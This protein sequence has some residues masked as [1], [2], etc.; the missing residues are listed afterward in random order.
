MADRRLLLWAVSV[1]IVAALALP[2]APLVHGSGA[3]TSHVAIAS[4]TSPHSATPRSATPTMATPTVGARAAAQSSA[5]AAVAAAHIPSRYVFYPNYGADVQRTGNVITP[6]SVHA[7]API[8]VADLGVVNTSGTAVGTTLTTPSFWGSITFNSLNAFYLDDD[9]PDY[10][11]AQLNTVVNNITLFGQSNNSFWTQNVF[12]YSSR[13]NLLQFLDNIWNFSSPAFDLTANVF[14]ATSPNGTL[15]APTFYYGLGPVINITMP[16]TVNVYTNVTTTNVNGSPD[17]IVY[18]NYSVYKSGAWVQGGAYDWAIFNSQVPG[19]PTA[20]IEDPLYLVDGTN[21]TP[22][23]FLPYDAELVFCG[24]GGGSSTEILGLDATLNLWYW[25]TTTDTY[26]T[27]PVAEAYGTDTGETAD[28]IAEWYDA[29]GTVHAGPGPSLPYLFWN[30]SPTAAPG[31]ITIGGSVTPSNAFVFVNQSVNYNF[32]WAA[33]APVPTSGVAGYDVPVG[34][35]SVSV[36]LSNYDPMNFTILGSTPSSYLFTATLNADSA[37]GI[38][39]P[40]WAWDNAQLAAISTSGAGTS[41][42]PYMIANDQSGSLNPEFA[43]FNDFT[44]PAFAG[45]QLVQTTAYVDVVSPASFE[46]NFEGRVLHSALVQGLPT[47]NNLQ[48]ELYG[49]SHVSLWNATGITGWFSAANLNGFPLA[50]LMVWNSSHDLIG[51]NTFWVEGASLLIFGAGGNTVWGNTFVPSPN[52]SDPAFADVVTW[53]TIPVGPQVYENND[54]IYNNAFE[55]LI[56]A[57]SPPSTIYGETFYS[58]FSLTWTDAWNISWAPASAWTIDNGFN[59]T[60]VITGGAYQGGNFWWNLGQF[61]FYLP[62]D[63]GGLIF[64]GG[65]WLPLFGD[66]VAFSETGLP[67]GTPWEVTIAG[68]TID[69]AAATTAFQLLDGT[70]TYAVTP[71]PG[72]LTNPASGTLTLVQG[73]AAV[74]VSFVAIPTNYT[75]TLAESGLPGG[76]AWTATLNGASSTSTS[77]TIAFTA[78]N[79][80]YTWGVTPVSGEILAVAS[81]IVTVDGSNVTVPVGFSA[82]AAHAYSVTFVALGLASGTTW[83][84]TL[85]GTTVSSAL[86]EIAFSEPNGSYTYTVGAVSGYTT[87]SASGTATVSGSSPSYDIPFTATSVT[88]SGTVSPATATVTVDGASVSVTGGSFSLTVAPGVHAVRASASGYFDYANNVS[89]AVAHNASVAIVLNAQSSGSSTSGGSLSGTN[90]ALLAGLGVLAVIFLIGMVYFWS[91]VRR[92]PV[93]M[94]PEPEAKSAEASGKSGPGG[95]S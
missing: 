21:L 90:L 11:G 8:G 24:P 66:A 57:Y 84:V 43:R 93:V 86:Q 28:G 5:V 64:V 20:T 76:T 12:E 58:S 39:T 4:G 42:N 85:S 17:D 69:S 67:A 88:L 32:S 72:Y 82:P 22:T 33:W 9:S 71:E 18:F 60:G 34:D 77:A 23:N 68:L 31:F 62:Y 55:T 92:G 49:T 59:L 29:T 87:T 15:V 3:A 45:L 50:P 81:G 53:G 61:G 35:Y 56:P 80:S 10:T 83:S 2:A 48:I 52:L 16:F 51:N 37:M 73:P 7:P 78:T 1:L 44:F 13:S 40:L 27:V 91:K 25:N 94:K 95:S 36:M 14:N 54:L 6:L 46:V 38:Y 79:G 47:S 89:V 30:A 75:V 63:G 26:Q 70:Y 65:D 74:V 19:S 41:G